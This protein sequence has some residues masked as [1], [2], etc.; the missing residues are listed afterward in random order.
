LANYCNKLVGQDRL[1][2]LKLKAKGFPVT[3]IRKRVYETFEDSPEY[4]L[5]QFRRWLQDDNP[6]VMEVVESERKE[7]RKKSYASKDSRILALIEIGEKLFEEILEVNWQQEHKRG[8]DLTK[9]F[10]LTMTDLRTE[11]DPFG[12][13]DHVIASAY[14]EFINKVAG[15]APDLI[16]SPIDLFNKAQETEELN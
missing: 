14:E 11:T 8:T 9:E 5:S 6:E 3:E 4:S 7:A 15:K 2:A 13:G 10:R 16:D 1:L 12:T